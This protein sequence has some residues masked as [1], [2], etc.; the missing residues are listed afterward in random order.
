MG[1]I[2]L[3]FAAIEDHFSKGSARVIIIKYS[4]LEKNMKKKNKME[5][6]CKL[7]FDFFVEGSYG[8]H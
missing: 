7:F 4:H 8:V 1:F 3:V 2:F 6:D 5:I